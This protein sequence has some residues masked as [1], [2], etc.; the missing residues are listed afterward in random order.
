MGIRSHLDSFKHESYGQAHGPLDPGWLDCSLG[1]NPCGF[2]DGVG[3]AAQGLAAELINRYPAEDGILK[4]AIAD[5]WSGWAP[6]EEDR[7]ELA[8]GSIDGIVKINKMFIDKGTRVLGY[9]PQFP[10]F[11]ADVESMGGCFEAVGMRGRNGRFDAGRFMAR[12]GPE[13]ALCYLDNPNNPTGQI[14][15]LD[16]IEAVAARAAELDIC[17]LVDEAYGEF[18]DRKAS[19]A[20]LLGRFDN[21]MVLRTFSKGYGLAG[22]RVGYVLGSRPLMSVYRKVAVPFAAS[23]PGT[24]LA[25]EALKD[26]AF[27]DRS[28]REIACWKQK[29]LEGAGLLEHLHTS[30]ETPILTLIHPDDSIDLHRALLEQKVVA[31]PGAGFDGLGPNSVRIRVHRDMDELAERIRRS[32]GNC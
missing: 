31:V 18:M 8:G 14:I 28:R 4:K 3:R 19:A 25:V 9:T 17:V 22:L 7:I 29:L 6:L 26:Q 23:G 30:L 20:T 21:L 2:P 16:Q 24:F 1:I 13:H 12:M 11:R 15:P 5:H 32:A 27:L 10:D